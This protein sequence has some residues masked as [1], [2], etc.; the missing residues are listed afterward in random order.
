M[1]NFVVAFIIPRKFP[2]QKTPEVSNTPDLEGGAAAN[3]GVDIESAS[4]PSVQPVRKPELAEV[5][6]TTEGRGNRK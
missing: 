3:P 6:T 4:G 2:H 1:L 5:P